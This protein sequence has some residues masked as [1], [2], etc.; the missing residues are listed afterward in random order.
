MGMKKS[1]PGKIKNGHWRFSWPLFFI[2]TNGYYWKDFLPL[3]DHEKYLMAI[4]L[5]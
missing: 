5:F 4:V 2:M 1:N 3:L